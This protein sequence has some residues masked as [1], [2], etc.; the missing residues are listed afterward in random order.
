MIEKAMREGS[1]K[2]PWVHRRLGGEVFPCDVHLTRVDHGGEP[3]LQ[4][5]VRD[6]SERK[7]EEEAAKESSEF[8]NMILDAIPVPIFYKDTEGRFIGI[9]KAYEEFY[10]TTRQDLA[11]KTVFDLFPREI[12][13]I[14][15]NRDLDLLEHP[16]V[17]EYEAPSANARGDSRQILLHK[18]TFTDR[19]GR[20]RGTLGASIDITDR[21]RVESELGHARK[22][23]AVGQL[24]A[25]IAHEINT[26]AQYVGDGVYFLKEAFEAYQQLINK[27]RSA[28]EALK[29]GG[30]DSGL[31]NEIREFENEVDLEYIEANLPG[32]FDR[33]LDGISRISTIVRAM[34]EFSHPDQREKSLADLN[35]A[36]Q[37]T[38]IIARNEYKYVAD[39]ETEFGDL[40]VVLCHL[41]DLNQ[42]FLNLI[43]NAAHAIGDVVG[44]EGE[45]GQIRIR[46]L[47]ESDWVRI[48]II[49]TGAGIPES[50]RNRIFEPFFTTKEVGKGSG[51]G[52]AIARSIVVDKH[53]GSLTFKSEVGKGTTFTLRLPVD[54]KGP[55][56]GEESQ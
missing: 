36:L 41:S 48:D 15:H 4:A 23:E 10:G 33:C 25:G 5:I 26:P 9:N 19:D 55:G 6:S 7:R 42:V 46:T 29:L 40:P 53:G 32:S 39:M 1:A 20:L 52:L 31:F 47:Q 43:V 35:Q 11:G 51:Q 38:L 49:D 30:A 44:R 2:F 3:F 17:Q 18:A 16:G 50:I 54:G 28:I 37:S 13:E 22:L 56:R 24:A 8:L 27:Y 45:K 34:K 14:Y 12:A 21:K